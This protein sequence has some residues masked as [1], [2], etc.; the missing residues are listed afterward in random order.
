MSITKTKS[1]HKFDN[2]DL[3]IEEWTKDNKIVSRITQIYPRMNGNQTTVK[4]LVANGKTKKWYR[5]TKRFNRFGD[6]V[7]MVFDHIDGSTSIY[8]WIGAIVR[9]SNQK[10]LANPFAKPNNGSEL[11]IS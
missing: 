6:Q 10:W 11:W 8:D 2:H 7:G 3:V 9:K 5:I 4:S 1:V